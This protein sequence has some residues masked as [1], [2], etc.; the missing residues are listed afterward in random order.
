MEKKLML[1]AALV[2][3][4]FSLFATDKECD[5]TFQETKYRI[6]S[7]QT[8]NYA[9]SNYT[10]AFTELKEQCSTG[11]LT[12]PVWVTTSISLGV[13]YGVWKSDCIKHLTPK[14]IKD[15][16]CSKLYVCIAEATQNENID[17]LTKKSDALKC[18]VE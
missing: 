6:V 11:E 16:V 17:W 3:V 1:S 9:G 4:S 12:S 18:S 2:L 8:N 13:Q 7:N 15:S 5:L 14:E 10:R